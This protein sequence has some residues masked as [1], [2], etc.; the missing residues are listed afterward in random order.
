MEILI[1]V[2]AFLQVFIEYISTILFHIRGGYAN[3]ADFLRESASQNL[4]VP[5]LGIILIFWPILLSLFMSLATAW[6]WIFWLVTSILLGL[7]QVLYASYQ[8]VMI[9][10]DIF[11]LSVLKTYTMLSNF[12]ISFVLSSQKRTTSRRKLWRTSLDACDTYEDFLKIR[13]QAKATVTPIDSALPNAPFHKRSNSFSSP[14][15]IMD[16]AKYNRKIPRVRSFTKG[17]AVHTEHDA[18]GLQHDDSVVS[19]LG[20]TAADLLVTTTRQIE[21]AIADGNIKYLKF[22]LAAVMKRNHLNTDEYLVENSRG[23]ASTGQYG[24]SAGSRTMIRNYMNAVECGLDYIAEQ[25]SNIHENLKLVRKMKQNMGRTALMLSGGGAQAMY[26]LG[27]IRALIESKQYQDISV[28]SGTSGGSISAAMCAIKT[29]EE[30]ISEVCVNTVSTDFGGTGEQAKN[31]IRWFPTMWDMATY[32]FKHKLLVDSETF[33]KTCEFYYKDITFEEAFARTGKHV[34]ITVSASRANG[35]T[36]QRLLLN[37]I[38]TPHVTI[39]S[40]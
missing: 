38:S 34:C 15:H 35:Y 24:L 7:L 14:D 29:A 33:Q 32:W 11:G 28:I 12:A 17:E 39:A 25:S 37:H 4:V 31:N 8:F 13:I 2:P 27:V 18:E 10:L 22:L 3:A 20:S 23:V 21:E 5:I 19:E 30:L 40:A 16:V 26:H 1:P 6:A 36:A 9:S